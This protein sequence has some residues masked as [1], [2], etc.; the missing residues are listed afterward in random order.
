L[1]DFTK[2]GGSEKDRFALNR[3]IDMLCKGAV[4][5]HAW[6]KA[7]D[8]LFVIRRP[9]LHNRP[10]SPMGTQFLYDSNLLFKPQAEDLGA[11]S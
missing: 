9:I 3:K 4:A 1:D 7:L 8:G 6:S 11:I 5:N 10:S 2:A